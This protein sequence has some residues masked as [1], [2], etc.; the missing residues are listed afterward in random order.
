MNNALCSQV[1]ELFKSNR[2]EEAAQLSLRLAGEMPDNEDNWNNLGAIMF[3]IQ[4]FEEAKRCFTKA[5]ELNPGHSEARENL[6]RMGMPYDDEKTIIAKWEQHTDYKELASATWMSSPLVRENFCRHITGNPNKEWHGWL[7]DIYPQ[8][9]QPNNNHLLVLGC[10]VALSELFLLDIGFCSTAMA[11]DIVPA[12]IESNI[13]SASQR[14]YGDK[15]I[16]KASNINTITLPENQ[17][18]LLFVSHSFHHFENLE[19]IMAEVRKAL[20]P[21][22]LLIIDDYVGPSRFQFPDR[23][24]AMMNDLLHML[25]AEWL[26]PDIVRWPLS[27]FLEGDP[28]EAVRSEEI[29]PLLKDHFNITHYRPY[30]GSLLHMLLQDTVRNFSNTDPK[31]RAIMQLLIYIENLAIEAGMVDNSFALIVAEN[32]K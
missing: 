13:A 32:Q 23:Q 28:S 30:G 6:L 17:F 10:G 29:V 11:I 18:D 3:R 4:K 21:G 25:P 9:R 22:A 24:F 12:A 2:I 20:K 16:Y 26:K 27:V 19:H 7:T 14:G 15:V 1:E 5:L 31:D 8:L